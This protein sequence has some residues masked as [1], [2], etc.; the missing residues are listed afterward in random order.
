MLWED[1]EAAA[2]A[3]AGDNNQPGRAADGELLPVVSFHNRSIC[4]ANHLVTVAHLDMKY[5]Y[6]FNI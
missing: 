1:G 3:A 2:A 4:F 6:I 5:V